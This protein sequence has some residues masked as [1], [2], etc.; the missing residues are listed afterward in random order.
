M[1][2]ELILTGY[3]I[4]AEEPLRLGLVNEV[5]ELTELIPAA[6]AMAK[7]IATN[8]PLAV[9]YAIEAVEWGY[10]TALEE[11]LFL[12]ASLFGLCC[13][14]EDMRDGTRAFIEKR[15]PKFQGR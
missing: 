13:A 6:E 10:G 3:V 9:K 8:A 11:G 14:T 12:E 1:A 7:K 2:H 5:V 15:S 4:S